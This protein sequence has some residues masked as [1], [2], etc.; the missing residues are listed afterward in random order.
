MERWKT[1]SRCSLFSVLQ[2]LL[3]V[4]LGLLI[5]SPST[6]FAAELSVEGS[7]D[8]TPAE[9]K[10]LA[11]RAAAL[12]NRIREVER[13]LSEAQEKLLPP[14]DEDA[15][16]YRLELHNAMSPPALPFAVSHIRVSFEGRPFVYSQR[17]IVLTAERPLPLF[18]GRLKEG[19]YLMKIQ[20][21]G[22]PLE[23][24]RSDGSDAPWRTLDKLITLD[25]TRDGGLRQFHKI[26]LVANRG[27]GGIELNW[28][29]ETAKTK[30]LEPKLESR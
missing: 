14:S 20:F 16:E 15:V 1:N 25:V 12:S 7:V 2:R 5:H 30:A 4:S 11:Q 6:L 28:A 17:A 26:E 8:D 10:K 19:K 13:R 29:G 21:Q 27:S 3:I 22:A 23:D 9:I 18:L 24:V